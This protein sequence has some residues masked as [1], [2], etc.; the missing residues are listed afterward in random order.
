MAMGI[1]DDELEPFISEL[2]SMNEHYKKES[3][4]VKV[5]SRP[6][7]KAKAKAKAKAAAVW[8]PMLP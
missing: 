7:G 3:A 4:H 1:V 2:V 8:A 6:P 5:H